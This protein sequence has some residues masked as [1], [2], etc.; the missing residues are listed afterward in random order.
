MSVYN[1]TGND[2]DDASTDAYDDGGKGRS[3]CVM[4]GQKEHVRKD[5]R[6]T[7]I[8]R[9]QGVHTVN[10]TDTR[11]AYSTHNGHKECIKYRGH[12]EYIQ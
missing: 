11:S 9:T 3:R 12:K 2:V 4:Q 7:Y 1:T 10:T 6:S 8:P 5:T